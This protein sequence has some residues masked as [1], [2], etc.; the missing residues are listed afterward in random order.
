MG[1]RSSLSL[2]RSSDRDCLVKLSKRRLDINKG[3]EEIEAARENETVVE[4]FVTE[5]NKGGVVV[6]VKGVRVF[7]PLPDRSAP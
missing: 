4:G 1:T 2:C 6:S 5:D 7:V 3:W